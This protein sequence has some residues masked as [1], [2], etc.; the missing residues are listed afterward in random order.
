MPYKL[1]LDQMFGLDMW[2]KHYV[3][4]VMME[5]IELNG[6]SPW[7][8]WKEWYGDLSQ[9]FHGFVHMPVFNFRQSRIQS[10][11]V[12]LDYNKAKEMFYE[13]DK[14]FWDEEQDMIKDHQYDPV[15]ERSL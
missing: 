14:K 8:T 10:R 11:I 7:T 1:Y 12:G 13:E 2:L 9:L 5:D 15:S 3:P 4:K 6:G